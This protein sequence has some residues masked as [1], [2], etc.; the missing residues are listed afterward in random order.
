[1]VTQNKMRPCKENLIIMKIYFKCATAFDLNKFLTQIKFLIF[2][3]TRA[4]NSY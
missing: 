2:P 3:H 1:M 4:R